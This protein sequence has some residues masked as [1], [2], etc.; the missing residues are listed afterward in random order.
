MPAQAS[1]PA[2]SRDLDASRVLNGARAC[3]RAVEPFTS[4]LWRLRGVVMPFGCDG[5][6]DSRLGCASAERRIGGLSYASVY[7]WVPRCGHHCY[8]RCDCSGR[9]CAG[10]VTENVLYARRS[11]LNARP[12]LKPEWNNRDR[13][14]LSASVD[15]APTYA[16][17][18]THFG[19]EAAL[20]F[21]MVGGAR[22]AWL[23]GDWWLG[24]GP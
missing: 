24:L 16:E 8:C 12:T 7:C 3:E 11:P 21:W 15:G 13:P 9:P 20:G 18:C 5:D 6:V 19:R 4:A 23:S 17:N 14:S 10:I 2:A 1:G 22:S